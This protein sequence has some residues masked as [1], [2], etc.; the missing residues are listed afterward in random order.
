VFAPKW[1][2]RTS[3]AKTGVVEVSLSPSVTV[4]DPA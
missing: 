4:D 3:E 2:D 1:K